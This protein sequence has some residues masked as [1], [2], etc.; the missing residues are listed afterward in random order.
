MSYLKARASYSTNLLL[1]IPTTPEDSEVLIGWKFEIT[2]CF[3][4]IFRCDICFQI[5][6]YYLKSF[7]NSSIFFPYL[8]LDSV[9]FQRIEVDRCVYAPDHLAIFSSSAMRAHKWY[10]FMCIMHAYVHTKKKREFIE[11]G[12]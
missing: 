8:L 10:L 2:L 12:C 3:Y 6:F 11:V 1:N 7:G 5:F 4:L 9:I